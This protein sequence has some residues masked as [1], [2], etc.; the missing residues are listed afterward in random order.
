MTH[1]L[2]QVTVTNPFSSI[3]RIVS[4]RYSARLVLLLGTVLL[5][6][7]CPPPTQKTL[8]V[9][10]SAVRST[11][12]GHLT[13]YAETR[14]GPLANKLLSMDQRSHI[15]QLG[16]SHTAADFF[17]GTLRTA[18]QQRYGNAGPG[19]LPPAWIR[20]QR[21]ATLRPGDAASHDWQLSNSRVQQHPNFPLGG[22]L[23]QPLQQGS[24][25]QLTPYS[26]MH[27]RFNV[28][29]LYH[30]PAQ[31]A[32]RLNGKTVSL[33]ASSGWQWS[34]PHSVHLPLELEVLNHSYPYLGGWLLDNG[35]PGVLLSSLGLNGAT[36]N[37][38]DKWGPD[39]PS[40]L[41]SLQPDLLILAYGTNEAFNDNLDSGA[42]YAHLTRHIQQLRRQQPQAAL[43]IIGAPDAIKNVSAP[44]CQARRPAQLG[45]VQAIQRQV[46]REQHTLFWDWQ[47]MMGGIC[48]FSAWQA[49][50]LAQQDG[51][52]FTS[53]GYTASANALFQDLARHIN[54][55]PHK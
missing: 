4:S 9:L 38:L 12:S 5:S 19:W 39:W 42:Y 45:K 7:C 14:L 18:L 31:V 17:T 49:R 16:D 33:A 48:S 51:V 21:S 3:R 55:L 52:H 40:T 30:S 28:R 47:A 50:A 46:A 34:A 15:I 54:Q 13:D 1:N 24:R 27:S 11:S 26:P 44:N 6:S 43:L 36:I 29:A 8:P 20:G 32:V 41:Q 23:V 53:A 25:L 10:V 22:I 35:Q 2:H 37:M